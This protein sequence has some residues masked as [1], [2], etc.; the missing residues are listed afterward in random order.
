MNDL[1]DDLARRKVA[2][3]AGLAGSAELAGKGTTDLGRN[4]GG[5]SIVAADQ[6]AF[7]GITVMKAEKH[8]LRPAAALMRDF[9]Q[10]PHLDAT[11]LGPASQ[12]ARQIGMRTEQVAICDLRLAASVQRIEFA[13]RQA[14]R[15]GWRGRC[16]LSFEPQR[17]W[18]SYRHDRRSGFPSPAI[19]WHMP[20]K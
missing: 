13:G 4:T 20:H 15:Q 2:L 1:F 11:S 10:A 7:D 16:F 18:F 6:D 5:V 9:A 19:P 12:G 3:E 8:F 17:A 14:Q